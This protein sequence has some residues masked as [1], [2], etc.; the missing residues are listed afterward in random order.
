MMDKFQQVKQTLE[1][2]VRVSLHEAEM[3]DYCGH[4]VGISGG[5]LFFAGGAFC[6]AFHDFR[7][8]NSDLDIYCGGPF[9]KTLLQSRLAEKRTKKQLKQLLWYGGDNNQ[10]YA[11]TE[12]GLYVQSSPVFKT[13]KLINFVFPEIWAK[14]A[15][16]IYPELWTQTPISIPLMTA[17]SLIGTFDYYHTMF[18]APIIRVVGRVVGMD[19]ESLLKFGPMKTNKEAMRC[20]ENKILKINPRNALY[21][22]KD[23]KLMF[24]ETKSGNHY[25]NNVLG[26]Y[27]K[28]IGRG[29]TPDPLTEKLF[30]KIKADNY[31]GSREVLK[32][33]IRAAC[34]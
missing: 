13:I 1:T 23:L 3:A 2:L 32:E 11:E 5:T 12:N 31:G 10:D 15:A 28:F 26:R 25:H 33:I 30:L 20:V 22:Y 16:V 4:L 8:E 6:N 9:S 21:W 18:A 34:H 19:T 29:F 17:E 14:K 27:E 24:N 7:F